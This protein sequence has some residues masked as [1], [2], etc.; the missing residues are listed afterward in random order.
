M[1]APNTPITLYEGDLS[2]TTKSGREAKAPGHISLEFSPRPDV[3][4]Q[5]SGAGATG[6][7]ILCSD[8]FGDSQLKVLDG[9]G[10][11][12]AFVTGVAADLTGVL[13]APS[14]SGTDRP[15][16]HLFFHLLNFADVIGLPVYF[17]PGGGC[18]ASRVQLDA[19]GWRIV[20]D[21]VPGLQEV[22]LALKA[23]S[24]YAITHIGRVERVDAAP[25]TIAEARSLLDA[26]YYFFSFCMGKW[27]AP[28]LLVEF[29]TSGNLFHEDWFFRTTTSWRYT[30]SWFS[31]HQ[32]DTL[33][34]LFG[35]FMTRWLQ[36]IWNDALR[37][38]IW[39]YISANLQG[40][41]IDGGIILSQV[42]LELLAWM[43]F[44]ED[45]H[46]ISKMGFEDLPAADKL[47]LLLDRMRVP[48]D[49]PTRLANLASFEP[50]KKVPYAPYKFVEIRN[51]LVHPK[52]RSAIEKA[53]GAI[54]DAWMLGLWYTELALLFVCGY[55]GQYVNR[56]V[57]TYTNEV[58]Q[59]PWHSAP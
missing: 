4:F 38:S 51:A 34:S 28:A 48:L 49:V 33:Q 46:V 36:P 23:T 24:G 44:V 43:I 37:R 39:W 2:I 25:F 30:Q 50:P 27:S 18:T 8:D 57:A 42:A 1:Q 12:P 59:V 6:L 11:Y 56:N 15:I 9:S 41:G 53:D 45:G 32:R 5:M 16:R 31:N 22:K 29:D 21:P 52:N 14:L 58:E 19:R 26:L 7:D 40:G 10:S 20:L 13:T 55:S 35:G 3:R 47:R 17:P 54:Q